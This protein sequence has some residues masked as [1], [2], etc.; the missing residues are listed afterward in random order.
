M[1]VPHMKLWTGQSL[2]VQRFIATTATVAPQRLSDVEWSKRVR[3]RQV[4]VVI[5]GGAD[6]DM[7]WCIPKWETQVTSILQSCVADCPILEMLCHFVMI[8]MAVDEGSHNGILCLFSVTAGKNV[9]RCH[10]SGR[11]AYL[12]VL[13]YFFHSW[14]LASASQARRIVC[15]PSWS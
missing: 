9:G 3:T 8:V 11:P 15:R 4:E 6:S 2:I 1:L 13:V 7:T 14:S 5:C 10:A 12:L